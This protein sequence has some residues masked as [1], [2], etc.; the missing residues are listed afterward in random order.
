MLVILDVTYVIII[1]MNVIFGFTFNDVCCANASLGKMV[2]YSRPI[3]QQFEI[4]TFRVEKGK[5]SS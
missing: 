1:F 3:A 5:L 4:E 2:V